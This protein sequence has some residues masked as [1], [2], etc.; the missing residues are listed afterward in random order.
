MTMLCMLLCL[1]VEMRQ[2]AAQLSVAE[3]KLEAVQK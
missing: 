1:Q 2:I 3:D